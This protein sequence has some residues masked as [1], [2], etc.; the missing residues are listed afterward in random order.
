MELDVNEP[1]M[2]RAL[3]SIANKVANTEEPY[4]HVHR[5]ERKRMSP[6]P[7]VDNSSH[8][9]RTMTNLPKLD[10]LDKVIE[11]FVSRHLGPLV[12]KGRCTNMPK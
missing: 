11:M 1:Q 8:Q 7:V 5:S 12:G 3:I 2:P 9:S 4:K 6:L 10:I